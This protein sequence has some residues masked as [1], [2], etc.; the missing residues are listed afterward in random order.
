VHAR[1]LVHLPHGGRRRL[2]TGVRNAADHRPLVV[3]GALPQQNSA[4]VV[5][6]DGADAGK[7]QQLV[8]GRGPDPVD[9]VRSQA[10]H[11]P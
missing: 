8:T 6:D 2:L 7:P 1:L 11:R 9:E 10:R 3:V 5:E 4:L